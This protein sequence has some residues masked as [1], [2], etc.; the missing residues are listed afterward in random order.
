MKSSGKPWNT[1]Y[2]RM[3]ELVRGGA[4]AWPP[5]GSVCVPWST[6]IFYIFLDESAILF[7]VYQHKVIHNVLLSLEKHLTCTQGKLQVLCGLELIQVWA[8][9]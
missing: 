2:G 5:V 9:L 1:A 6:P 4:E 8:C 3:G 7:W